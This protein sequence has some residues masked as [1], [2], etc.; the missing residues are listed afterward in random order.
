MAI[1]A[2]TNLKNYIEKMCVKQAKKYVQQLIK[3]K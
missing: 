3:Q 2:N 1:D